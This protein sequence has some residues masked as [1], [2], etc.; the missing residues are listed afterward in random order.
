MELKNSKKISEKNI[1]SLRESNKKYNEDYN[2]LYNKLVQIQAEFIGLKEESSE[3][4]KN[5]NNKELSNKE[6]DI[7]VNNCEKIIKEG[8]LYKLSDS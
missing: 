3:N 1:N 5:K 6:N 7:N 8:Y 2:K 4:S